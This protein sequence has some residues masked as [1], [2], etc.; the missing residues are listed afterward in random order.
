MDSEGVSL[1][2]IQIH[3]RML[4]MVACAL[5]ALM[6]V[7]GFGLHELH[8]NL[9]QDRKN[10]TQHLVQVAVGT[11]TRYQTLVEAGKMTLP[12][13]QREAAASVAQLRYGENDYFWINDLNVRMVV[14]PIRPELNGEVVDGIRDA[15]GVYLFSQFV[16]VA[17]TKGAGFVSYL[18]PK[19][20]QVQASKKL[21]Y[22]QKFEPWGW[23]VGSG[24]YLDDVDL[25]FRE[26]ASTFVA[27]ILTSLL[28]VW[29]VSAI[30]GR[31][32]TAPL[33]HI[34]KAM[35]RLSEGDVSVPLES[36]D[37]SEVG[38][39]LGAMRVFRDNFSTMERLRN[40]RE[41]SQ[42]QVALK[43]EEL[44]R[45]ISIS[46]TVVLSWEDDEPWTLSYVSENCYRILNA[47][48]DILTLKPFIHPD[49]LPH[50]VAALAARPADKGEVNL[51]F[52]LQFDKQSPRWFE[53][54]VFPQ[55]NTQGQLLQYQGLLHDITERRKAEHDQRMAAVL[56]RTTNEALMI[57]SY[58][59][60]I[61][62]VNPAFTRITGYTETDVLG[63][64]PDIL[65]S[66]HHDAEFYQQMWNDLEEN[67]IWE[68]EIWNRRKN[69]ETYPEW[70]SISTVADEQ[71]KTVQYIAAFSDITRRKEAEDTI[72]YQANFDS[73]TDLPNRSLFNDRLQ[74][75]LKRS[76]R[77]GCQVA[78]LFIDL[79]RFKYVNDT[80]GHNIGDQ[81]LQEVATRLSSSVRDS[82]TV[83]RLGGDE[84]TVILPELHGPDG[85]ARLAQGMI[86]KLEERYFIEGHELFISAS[87]GITVFPKDADNSLDL[88]KNADVAMYRAKENGRGSY[89]FY[90]ATMNEDAKQHH[91]I[92]QELRVAI[93]QKQFWIHYQ[94]YVDQASG[95]ITG[96]EALI[97]WKNSA[98]EMVY[99]DQFIPVAEDTGLIVPIG[100]WVLRSVMETIAEWEEEGH[101]DITFS[102]N[103]SARQFQEGHLAYQIKAALKETGIKPSNLMLE[104]TESL[105]IR[106]PSHTLNMLH[107][108]KALGVRVALD[109]FGTGYSS[110]GY[111]KQFPI[112]LLKIDRSFIN[113]IANSKDD[114]T[115]VSAIVNMAHSLGVRVIGEGIENDQ[116]LQRVNAHECDFVQ[117]FHYSKPMPYQ[118]FLEFFDDYHEKC[119]TGVNVEQK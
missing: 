3:H 54:C 5:I 14:H 103:V 4:I 83:A 87:I 102:V 12:D 97:R 108:I 57:S 89:C 100:L 10:K 53:C 99:P 80:L 27:V 82:D 69:G 30:V 65:Q 117:G 8:D 17:K 42:R 9:I 28:I 58:D 38:D 36:L 26:A 98:G 44:E 48:V 45:I 67:G 32:I 72:R 46:H 24:I 23:V 68:G 92:E 29:T 59:N 110:L 13:A 85:V 76:Q 6:F 91:K 112:D 115:M 73:L 41:E 101:P 81:L 66:G 7:G 18:W 88:I 52:R 96:V 86:D 33:S 78:L 40:E 75:E 90:T 34:R 15:N 60:K 21:S 113:G 105:M 22:V 64:G 51:E 93:E 104:I 61:E 106:D 95:R 19:P 111:L 114:E 31:S 25:I 70:L 62:M 49:D 55:F 77:S 107:E 1:K 20:G 118:A 109:D 56:F 35:L 79:D 50:M 74:T 2:H 43:R 84:F 37:R 116:Q 47:K 119:S 11:L 39:L 94:P 71:G 16:D 63:R